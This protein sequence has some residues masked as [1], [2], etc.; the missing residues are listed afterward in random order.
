MKTLEMRRRNVPLRYVGGGESGVE[1]R[2]KGEILCRKRSVGERIT[3]S[4]FFFWVNIYFTYFL[5][6][7]LYLNKKAIYK[8]VYVTLFFFEINMTHFFYSQNIFST[9]N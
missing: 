8:G 6:S 3:V 1:T 4:L 5:T 2:G 7:Y 9:K